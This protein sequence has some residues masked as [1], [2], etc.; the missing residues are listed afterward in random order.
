[1]T[2]RLM[3]VDDHPVVRQGLVAIFET[4]DEFE[5]VA[6]AGDGESAVEML[7]SQALDVILLDLQLPEMSGV[8]TIDAIREE[9]P[10]AR[11]LVFTAYDD[12]D[13]IVAAVRAGIEGYV[14]KGTRRDEL[15]DAIRTVASGGSLLDPSI[16]S[17]LLARVGEDD[18]AER[19][20]PREGEVLD[21]L[22]R[23]LSNREIANVLDITER[24]VKFHVSSILGKLDV[25]NRTEAVSRAVQL[26]LV[27][28]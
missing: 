21:L 1:M 4:S 22:A 16:A 3:L 12:D 11:I 27:E 6:Q 7:G 2:I 28:L 13:L 10:Q 24:T 17:K 20:T 8:D 23:G 19:L 5:V 18:P 25:E 9:N 26:G 14:L 15:F